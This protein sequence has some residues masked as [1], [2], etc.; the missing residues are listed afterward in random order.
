M[1][2]EEV[3]RI[4]DLSRGGAGVSR[5]PSGRVV[6][7][8]YSAPGDLV[9]VRIVEAEKRY[10]QGEI[11]EILEPSVE[12]QVP[13]CPVFGKCGGCQWQHLPYSLQWSTKSKGLLHAL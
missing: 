9:R 3:L 8:P 5:D 11:L 2:K 13:P 6:F 12:R 7:V 1:E 4:T 10:A